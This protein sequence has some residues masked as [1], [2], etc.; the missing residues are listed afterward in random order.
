MQRVVLPVLRKLLLLSLSVLAV[1][2]LLPGEV[3]SIGWEQPGEE[4]EWLQ[5]PYAQSLENN[6]HEA[7]GEVCMEWVVN[8]SGTEWLC[9]ATGGTCQ[10]HNFRFPGLLD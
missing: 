3:G 6:C 10:L 4:G 9:C 8:G 2:A 1:G 5:T 7:A